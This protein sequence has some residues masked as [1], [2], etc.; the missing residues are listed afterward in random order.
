MVFSEVPPIVPIVIGTQRL[1]VLE[2]IAK[3]LEPYF[4]EEN[5][6]VISSDFSHYPSYDDARKSDL[7]LAEAITSGGLEEFLKALMQI[8]RTRGGCYSSFRN[9]Q[10]NSLRY[11]PYLL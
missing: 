3:V 7:H 4:N 8:D 9:C 11:I 10:K 1:N 5:L 2:E 6:F